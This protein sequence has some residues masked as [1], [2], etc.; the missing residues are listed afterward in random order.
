MLNLRAAT[1]SGRDVCV[2]IGM[3]RKLKKKGECMR[4]I[5][6]AMACLAAGNLYASAKTGEPILDKTSPETIHAGWNVLNDSYLK[7]SLVDGFTFEWQYFMVHDAQKQFTGSIGYVLVDPRGRLGETAHV[8]TLTKIKST[9]FPYSIMPSGASVALAG[10]WGDGSQFSNYERFSPS[11]EVSKTD[12]NFSAENVNQG[13]SAQLLEVEKVTADGGIFRLKGTTE[14]AS[15]DLLVTPDSF[16]KS[17]DTSSDPFGPITASDVGFLPGERWTVHMQ[18]PRTKV[19]GTMKNLKTG[20]TYDIS[21]HGYRENSWGRWNFALDGWAFSIVSDAQSRVQWAWQSY[22]TSKVMDWLDVSFEDEGQAQN[23][24]F[25]AKDDTLRWKLKD[26]YFH[27]EARQ[28][29]PNSVE[30]V[31]QDK[32]YRIKASYDLTNK[33]LPMLSKATPLTSIFVIMIHMPY[34][35]GTIERVDSGEL[36]KTFEG[37]GGG[38]FSTTRSIW[39][40]ISEKDCEKWGDRFNTEYPAT[41]F[42]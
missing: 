17:G 14:D 29:V 36:I 21:G 19:E 6:C 32:N 25:F 4:L 33:Q 22:H 8:D 15:W 30:V 31:A 2:V 20:E 1:P 10:T 35:K 39:N 41:D 42:Q 7:G 13:F 24:R 3:T 16:E 9:V 12:K 23:L 28:C 18:W 40:N 11:Y 38:E 5:S 26:W 34:I 27:P 37:Q